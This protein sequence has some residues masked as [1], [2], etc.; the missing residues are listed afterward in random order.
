[1]RTL[2]DFAFAVNSELLMARLQWDTHGAATR[3]TRFEV[4]SSVPCRLVGFGSLSQ[5]RR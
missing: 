2:S 5:T 3:K 1:M 4:P